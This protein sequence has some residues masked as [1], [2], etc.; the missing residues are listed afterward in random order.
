MRATTAHRLKVD[1]TVRLAQ[2][3]S[4]WCKVFLFEVPCIVTAPPGGGTCDALV[5]PCNERLEGTQFTPSEVV[6]NLPTAG[7]VIYPPQSIDGL[8]TE[9]GGPELAAACSALGGLPTGSAAI[10]PAFGELLGTYKNIV[11]AC[12]PIYHGEDKAWNGAEAD[13]WSSALHDCYHATYSAAD[14]AG[15]A[16]LAM[17][18]LGA[19]ARGAPAGKAAH[20][21]A[22]A[23]AAWHP[24]N[25]APSTECLREVRFAVQHPETAHVL[26]LALDAALE[27]EGG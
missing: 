23:T 6:A 19:G 10:T 18:L 9:L 5:N 3:K 13:S 26:R 12:A 17:P 11:H 24:R 2:W 14:D 20:I 4:A 22:T 16:N 1:P 27:V 15:L 7:T 8:V 21:A 25:R